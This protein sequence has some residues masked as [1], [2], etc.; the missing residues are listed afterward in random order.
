MVKY[1]CGA[2]IK[3]I[4]KGAE[5]WYIEAGWKKV[6]EA[7]KVENNDKTNTEKTTTT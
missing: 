5:K 2:I 6:Q 4:P 7:K 1:K 3:D